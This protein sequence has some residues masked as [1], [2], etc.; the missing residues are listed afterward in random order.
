[1]QAKNGGFEA[2]DAVVAKPTSSNVEGFDSDE[3]EEF[4]LLQPNRIVLKR[5]SH[6]SDAED[7]DD[8]GDNE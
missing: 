4:K 2:N 8:N 3:E 1:M 5:A 7:S 6:V